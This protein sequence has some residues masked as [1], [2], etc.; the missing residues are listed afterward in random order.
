[1]FGFLGLSCTFCLLLQL[2]FVG[3]ANDS[4]SS[5]LSER[6]DLSSSGSLLFFF[7][8]L[9]LSLLGVGFAITRHRGMNLG[10]EWS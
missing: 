3:I 1:M 4:C 2:S 5:G 10:P 9:S 6:L 7:F 8:F